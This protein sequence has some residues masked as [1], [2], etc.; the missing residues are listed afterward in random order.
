MKV[1]SSDPESAFVRQACDHLFEG[2]MLVDGY[3]TDPHRMVQRMN[4]ILQQAAR[5]EADK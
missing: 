5:A 2:S 1:L 4:E 3:L